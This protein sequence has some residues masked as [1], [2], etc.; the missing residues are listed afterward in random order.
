MRFFYWLILLIV[1]A[2]ALFA[3]QNSSAPL[4]TMK[5]LIWRFETSLI[6]TIL[7]SIG[8]GIITTLLFWIPRA[9]RASFRTR[10][11][12]SEIEDLE[13]LEIRRDREGNKVQER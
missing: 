9:I 12:H 5:F 3:N 11:L 4:V 13:D 10:K 1:A 7:G 8:L 2:I 6:S